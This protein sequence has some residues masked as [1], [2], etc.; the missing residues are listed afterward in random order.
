MLVGPASDYITYDQLVKHTLFP[1]VESPTARRV[2]KGRK[3]AAYLN[4]VLGLTFI[5][6]YSTLGDSIGY[7]RIVKGDRI[8]KSW[9]WWKRLAFVQ[10][11]GVIARTKY[12][13]SVLSLVRNADLQG[14]WSLSEV[15]QRKIHTLTAGRMHSD[16]PR[17]QWL[18]S[19]H[20]SD[21]VEQSQ[22]HQHYGH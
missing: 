19:Y 5:G 8:W 16:W 20:W 13:V 11:A 17:L 2:P 15:R 10:L 7:A 6:I 21:Q 4:L 1:P 3:R 12:Y 9:P 22:E 18:R 14:V